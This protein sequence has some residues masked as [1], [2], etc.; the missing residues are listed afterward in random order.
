MYSSYFRCG[1]DNLAPS[2]Q[3][4][5]VILNKANQ[6]E[7]S[8]LKDQVEEHIILNRRDEKKSVLFGSVHRK[9]DSTIWI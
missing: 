3:P 9:L 7:V 6:I 8:L 2:N 5:P 4:M 1:N